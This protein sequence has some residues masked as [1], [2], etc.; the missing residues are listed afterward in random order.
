MRRAAR[1]GIEIHAAPV[2]I[3]LPNEMA[4]A[5][6]STNRAGRRRLVDSGD[7]GQISILLIGMV[8]IVL[9]LVLGVV[10]ATSVHLSRIHLLDAADA[11]SLAAADT[12]DEEALYGHG[13]GT[14][15]P[16]TP[17]GVAAAAEE[18]LRLQP[19]PGRLAGWRIAPGTGTPDAR[20]AVV[21]VQGEARIPVVSGI[22]RSFGGSVSIT[23]ESRARSDLD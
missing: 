5:P 10:G 1:E 12:V 17:A 16:L 2:D 11:A 14:G 7:R 23:V 15:V 18:H 22:L 3:G 19:V 4:Q 20:T 13:L 6:D 21:R 8:S 9:L